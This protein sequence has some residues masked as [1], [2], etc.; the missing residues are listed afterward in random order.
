MP[1]FKH[2]NP[3]TQQGDAQ[4]EKVL[5]GTIL[6]R[7]KMEAVARWVQ[8]RNV[9]QFVLYEF[10]SHWITRGREISSPCGL[11]MNLSLCVSPSTS[12]S[13]QTELLSEM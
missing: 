6:I 8:C 9:V 13:L 1:L 11:L 3:S 4:S 7:E 12:C 5:Q 10:I 2:L